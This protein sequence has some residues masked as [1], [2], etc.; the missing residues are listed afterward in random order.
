M[1]MLRILYVMADIV[2]ADGSVPEKNSCEG[3]LDNLTVKMNLRFVEMSAAICRT[4][5]HNIREDL[6]LQKIFVLL[7]LLLLLL[8]LY[9]YT[10]LF[11]S[12]NSNL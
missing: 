4:T 1:E 12:K 6:G 5:Q 8:L 3:V 11:K 9:F 10:Y 2:N 7:L